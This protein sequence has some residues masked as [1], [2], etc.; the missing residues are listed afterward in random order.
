MKHKN[1]S[2]G[3]DA[4]KPA[5]STNGTVNRAIFAEGRFARWIETLVDPVTL[6]EEDTTQKKRGKKIQSVE[7]GLNSSHYLS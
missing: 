5:L 7:Q 1:L 2:A 3:R 6:V 4:V